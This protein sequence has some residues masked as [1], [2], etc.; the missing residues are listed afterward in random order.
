MS[1][2]ETREKQNL[3]YSRKKDYVYIEFKTIMPS[4]ISSQKR[5]ELREFEKNFMTKYSNN[6]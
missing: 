6:K 3:V 2:N 1:N 4:K 5:A